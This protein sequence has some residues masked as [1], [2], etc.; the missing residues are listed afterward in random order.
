MKTLEEKI[1]HIKQ[2]REQIDKL[3]SHYENNLRDVKLLYINYIKNNAS[4]RLSFLPKQESNILILGASGYL[5]TYVVEELLKAHNSQLIVLLHN[6]SEIEF[7][8]KLRI[9]EQDLLRVKFVAG[10]VIKD[11]LGMSSED[12]RY[13]VSNATA[14]INLAVNKSSDGQYSLFYDINVKPVDSIIEMMNL[15]SSITDLYHISTLGVSEGSDN[16]KEY[17]FFSEDSIEYERSFEN[18]E[19]NRFYYE[20]KYEAEQR[21]VEHSK[22]SEKR[23][24]IIRVG[25]IAFP[26]WKNE[27]YVPQSTSFGLLLAA[28]LRI[29]VFPN[30]TEKVL[31]FSFVEDAASAIAHIV[32]NEI[33]TDGK[34]D[35]FHLYNNE[36]YS[37]DELADFLCDVSSLRKMNYAD[38]YSYLDTLYSTADL[39]TK[40]C[41]EYIVDKY[42]CERGM[43]TTKTI[44]VN[45]RTTELLK[46]LG[47]KWHSLKDIDKNDFVSRICNYSFEDSIRN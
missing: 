7:L 13:V 32:M 28:M 47:F 6:T 20:T 40:A 1:S 23:I 18:I 25:N 38:M 34:L 16:K 33:Q 9:S 30:D 12:Y 21:L 11:K 46:S 39:K 17:S 44:I 2:K 8:K 3:A 19:L 29:G 35:V 26:F 45:D 43:H 36:Y 31:E 14:I 10:D 5:G 42:L 4:N 41:I 22:V 27:K 15:S 37:F 24:H